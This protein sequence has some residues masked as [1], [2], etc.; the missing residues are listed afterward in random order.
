MWA[1]WYADFSLEDVWVDAFQGG[2]YGSSC[3][4]SCKERMVMPWTKSERFCETAVGCSDVS[5][6]G[7]SQP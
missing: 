5:L 1:K 6:L 3:M 2:V 4:L 7:C